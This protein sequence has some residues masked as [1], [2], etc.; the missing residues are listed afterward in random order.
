M[1]TD[2]DLRSAF[3]ALA[4]RAPTPQE[5]AVTIPGDDR[6][7]PRRSRGPVL[8]AAAA[9]CAVMVAVPTVIA[10]LRTPDDA[11]PPATGTAEARAVRLPHTVTLPAPW[12]T[13]GRQ[14]DADSASVV[15]R[16]DP[17]TS[18]VVQ[19]Y[20]RARFDTGRI[21][22][23]RDPVT[24][25]GKDGYYAT[26]RFTDPKKAGPQ[27]APG[28]VWEYAP[29]SWALAHCTGSEGMTV[30]DVRGVEQQAADATSFTA[31]PFPVPFTL[32]NVPAGL[33]TT[34][35]QVSR[36]DLGTS[37]A[38]T[39]TAVAARIMF[40][41][42]GLE[43]ERIPDQI[44]VTPVTVNGHQAWFFDEGLGGAEALHVQ[45][46]GYY[47]E[48]QLNRTGSAARAALHRMA[49]GLRRAADPLDEATWPDAETA[50]PPRAG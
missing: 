48:L 41:K 34:Q 4:D 35:V 19:V 11:P 25:N 39:G 15:V 9:A 40:G 18:C 1:R 17:E 43:D 12:T 42:T 29:D 47:V 49:S 33:E 26:I 30:A 50:L 36:Q 28:V 38:L 13:T 31:Q 24:V 46:S 16:S 37:V 22:A 6:P 32:E 3:T 44:D 10:A 7:A 27:G 14:L 2:E 23:D 21:G 45:F 5:T 8:L 20:R